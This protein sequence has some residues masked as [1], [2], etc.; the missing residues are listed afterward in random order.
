LPAADYGHSDTHSIS[1]S[2]RSRS[3]TAGA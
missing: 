2:R 1:L 3:G